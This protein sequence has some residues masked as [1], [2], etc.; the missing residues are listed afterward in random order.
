MPHSWTILSE[1]G[2]DPRL[3]R[4]LRRAGRAEPE[5]IVV[6]APVLKRCGHACPATADALLSS[7]ANASVSGAFTRLSETVMPSPASDGRGPH[8][9]DAAADAEG[10]AR[11]QSS[12]PG[13]APGPGR[14]RA[15][16]PQPGAE[17]GSVASCGSGVRRRSI[18]PV[19][20]RS[21]RFVAV[22]LARSCAPTGR[23]LIMMDKTFDPSAVEARI[24]TRWEEAE[25][26]KAG[27]E[28]RK[29]AV[30]Y[31]I[32]IPPPNVTGSLHMGHAL[33][34]TIQDIL[35]PLRAHARQGRALAAGHGPCRHRHPDG[36]GAPARRSAR[37]SAATSAAR[38]S[39]SGSG[40]GRRSPAA[41]SC[42][43]SSA[44]APPATGRASASP[45]TRAC[46]RPCS[47]S[48]STSTSRA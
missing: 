1:H 13:R 25:A 23:Y 5:P 33:N 48:S 29:D 21:V 31:T 36:R 46:R 47:R 43:S 14:D 18:A 37:S 11:R 3:R 24:S 10:M 41:P 35:V 19:D 7:E 45:W 16:D 34:N 20:S 42:A 22:L 30:P 40:S 15:R 9:G 32:V 39:S 4:A 28:D 12:F 6:P 8:E 26:F 38:N 2:S 17:S 44:S 27:R